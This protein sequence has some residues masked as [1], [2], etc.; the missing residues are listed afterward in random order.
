MIFSQLEYL[1][2]FALVFVSYWVSPRRLKVPILLVASLAFY[3]SWNMKYLG[4]ILFSAGVDYFVARA[5]DGEKRSKIRN[6]LLSVSLI[7][8]LGVL[9]LFKYYGFFAQSVA[10]LLMELGIAVHMPSLTLL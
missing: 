5:I 3:G 1:F 9:A 7:T 10:S 4:L 8:N 2:F 6:R